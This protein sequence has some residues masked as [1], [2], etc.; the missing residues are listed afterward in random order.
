MQNL[1]TELRNFGFDKIYLCPNQHNEGCL[2]RKPS[3]AMLEK[4][5]KENNL[6]FKQCVVIGDRWTD[7][8]AA[9]EVGCK[10]IL[11]KTG[12]RTE[13]YQKFINNEFFG[14]WA[15]V[16]PDYIA[17]DLNKAVKWLMETL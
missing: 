5:A 9:N 10:K 4:A 12:S 2:C 11:I 1:E 15:E 3:P 6:D 7:L 14:R 8:L 13:T 17:G 16:K